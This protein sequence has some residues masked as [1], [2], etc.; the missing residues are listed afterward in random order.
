M[1]FVKRAFPN[2]RYADQRGMRLEDYFAI[3]LATS[4]VRNLG[5]E[6]F[7]LDDFKEVAEKAYKLADIMVEVREDRK[8]EGER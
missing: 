3:R 1:K 8:G 5:Y 2:S 7:E 4:M 6:L